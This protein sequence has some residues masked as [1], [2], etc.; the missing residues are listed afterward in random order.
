[1]PE[2]EKKAQQKRGYIR[3][4]GRCPPASRGP[5]KPACG[6]QRPTNRQT[7]DRAACRGQ[8]AGLRSPHAPLQHP[9][10][11]PI[12][13]PSPESLPPPAV[14]ASRRRAELPSQ[15][16]GTG[17]LRGHTRV[18]RGS[19]AG[20]RDPSSGSVFGSAPGWAGQTGLDVPAGCS[21]DWAPSVRAAQQEGSSL[22]LAENNASCA[23]SWF[24]Q[25]ASFSLQ[26]DRQGSD[27]GASLTP[28]M[29]TPPRQPEINLICKTYLVDLTKMWFIFLDLDQQWQS[30]TK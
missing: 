17:L 19:R 2:G 29:R 30:E 13:P 16:R 22:T 23:P 12:P 7:T 11:V 9:A 25:Q 14:S 21:T 27:G 1:M 26:E 5:I 24:V 28:S 8:R 18:A 4:C 10:K 20:K 3:T 6:R 15:G